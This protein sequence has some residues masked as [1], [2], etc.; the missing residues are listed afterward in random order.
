MSGDVTQRRPFRRLSQPDAAGRRHRTARQQPEVAAQT[1]V[2]SDEAVAANVVR[3]GEV[4]RAQSKSRFSPAFARHRRHH[5]L[6][7]RNYR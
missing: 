6:Q 4:P 1:P 7:M 5:R 3:K 2:R